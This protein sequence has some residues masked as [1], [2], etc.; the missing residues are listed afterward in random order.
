[1]RDEE[2]E[3]ARRRLEEA[4]GYTFGNPQLL[5]DALTHSSFRN[6][7]PDVAPTDNERLEFLGDAVLGLVVASLLADRFP[8]ATEGEL[9]RR[10]AN[11]VSEKGLTNVALEID[12]GAALRLGKGEEKSGGR[13]KSRLLSSTLEACVGAIYRDGGIDVAYDTVERLFSHEIEVSSAGRA[14]FKSR[15]Q[16]WAQ[17]NHRTTPTYSV[18]NTD[19]PDHARQ[20]LVALNLNGERVATGEGTS[21]IEAEQRAAAQ[22]LKQWT[23]DGN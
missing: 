15:A 2:Q 4:L 13:T 10:R 12:I 8:D 7:R 11:L 14:D 9:T 23:A 19:G 5:K 18:L 16:E 20:F 17:S 1:M 3:Q 22:A 21:K 6:E